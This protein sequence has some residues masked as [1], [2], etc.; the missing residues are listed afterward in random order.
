VPL[1]LDLLVQDGRYALRTLRSSAGLS[2]VVVL[3]LALGIR[4]SMAIFSV[5]NAVILRPIAY[6]APER[7]LWLST[8]QSDEPGIVIGPDFVDRREQATSFDRMFA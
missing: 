7:L 6:R 5:F 1:W 4:L 3:T 2:A 8:A